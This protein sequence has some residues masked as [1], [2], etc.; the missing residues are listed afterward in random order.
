MVA[1]RG[2]GPV[3][4]PGSVHRSASETGLVYRVAD[5]L[6]LCGAVFAASNRGIVDLDSQAALDL[7]A[8]G[9]PYFVLRRLFI[10]L[11]ERCHRPLC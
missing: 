4:W 3:D 7:V 8:D 5:A 11:A 1:H 10:Y 6:G 9:F 2:D